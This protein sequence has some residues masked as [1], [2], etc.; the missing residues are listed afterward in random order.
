VSQTSDETPTGP[1][2]ARTQQIPATPHHARRPDPGAATGG[3]Q[4]IRRWNTIRDLTAA[5]LLVVA[6]FLPWNLYFGFGIPDSKTVLFAILGAVTLLSLVSIALSYLGTRNAST[7]LRFILNVPY[8]LLGAGFIVF[9]VLQTIRSGGT[10]HVPGGIGPGAW[11]GTAG[12]LLSAQPLITAGDTEESFTRWRRYAQI[13]GYASMIGA[14]LSTTFN[15]CWRLRFAFQSSGE[16]GGFGKQNIAVIATALV[17]GLVALAAVL[18]ASRWSLRSTQASQLATIALGASTLVAGILVW[19]LPVGRDIDAFHAIAQNTSTAG[20]GFEGYFAWAAAA[21]VFA[22]RTLFGYGSGSPDD[23]GPWRAAA[24]KGLVLIAVWCVGSVLLRI[25]D[26]VINVLLNNPY[27]RYDTMTLAAFDLAT[28]VLAIW[29][30]RNLAKDAA[31]TRLTSWLCGLVVT[32]SISR[33]VVGIVLAPR[34]QEVPDGGGWSNPVYGNDLAQQITSIFDVVLCGLAISVLVAVV[35]MGR[36]LGRRLRRQK[37]RGPRRRSAQR[38]AAVPQRPAAAP[39]SAGAAPPS[40]AATSVIKT[41]GPMEGAT[42]V[43]PLTRS[44]RIFRGDDSAT[45]QI[46]IPKPQIYRPPGDSS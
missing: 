45:R 20:V 5:G 6:P 37:R 26:L 14:A 21:A 16:S 30:R 7:R 11:L 34:F 17:Y 2:G 13:I 3:T 9:D 39:P 44:P 27:S 43:M 42:S 22:P 12:A 29:L 24:R 23:E 1:I 4:R 41:R 18:V 15:L 33:V 25:T 28:A 19:F 40:A 38:P 36:V 35:V 31:S 10:V 46:S 32:L 8:L